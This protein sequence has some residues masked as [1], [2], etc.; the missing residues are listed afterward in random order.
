MRMQSA[1]YR[2]VAVHEETL[3][4]ISFVSLSNSM[5]FYFTSIQLV[6]KVL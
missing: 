6:F 5:D 2:H 3:R 4:F 1:N